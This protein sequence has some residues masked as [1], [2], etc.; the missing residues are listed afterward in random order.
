MKR[1]SRIALLSFI[2]PACLGCS[3]MGMASRG[4]T[5]IRGAHGSVF[6]IVEAPQA[7]YDTLGRIEVGRVDNSIG[8]VCPPPAH[9]AIEA[10]LRT[11]ASSAVQDLKGSDACRVDVDITFNKR[12]GGVTA[13]IGKDAL[14]IGRAAVHDRNDQQVADLLV[15]ITSGAVFT[16]TDEMAQEFAKILLGHFSKPQHP[17]PDAEGHDDGRDT[18]TTD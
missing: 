14:L 2:G 8:P 5:E 12:P 13:L 15:L 10:A 16:T 11:F 4:I 9:Q 18:H 1:I 7:F 3:P 17:Q 6:P